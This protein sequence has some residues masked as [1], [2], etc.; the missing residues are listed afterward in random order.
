MKR[1]DFLTA[2]GAWVRSSS[3]MTDQARDACAIHQIGR[4]G[5]ASAV[6]GWLVAIV[7]GVLLA[8]LLVHYL[9]PCEAGALC[10][11][12]FARCKTDACRQG[13]APCPT[14]EECASYS[15]DGAFAR[16]GAWL[17]LASAMVVAAAVIGLLI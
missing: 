1:P 7:V 6:A 16:F 11:A 12:P 14:P 5:V 17:S 15:D 2:P 10:A 3:R 4:S 8:L 13:R 9:T